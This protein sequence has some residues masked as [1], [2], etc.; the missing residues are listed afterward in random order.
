MSEEIRQI[1]GF[2][3][4]QALA[5]LGQLDSAFAKF[6][7]TVNQSAA[8]FNSFNQGAGKTVSAL[9]QMRSQADS[10]AAALG[11]LSATKA[12]SITAPT[13]STQGGQAAAASINSL[14][15]QTSAHAATAAGAF[16][17]LGNQATNA[18]T[19]SSR[20]ASN[21][22]LSLETI[23]RVIG[24]QVIVRA[25]NSIRSAVEDSFQGFIDFNRALAEIQTIS[26]DSLEQLGSEVR[27]LSDDFNTPILDV[28]KAK[29]EI[30]SN[31]FETTAESSQVLVAALKLSKVGLSDVGQAADLISTTLNS[32]N[33]SAG[34]AETISAK[35]FK[36]IELGR[37]KAS[38]LAS[39]FG[40]VAPV[41]AEI[42]ATEDEMLAAFSSITIGG[43]NASEAATQIRASLSALLKPS[44]DAEEALRKLGFETGE[45]LIQARGYRGALEALIGTTDGSTTSIAK[46][47]PNIRALNAVLRE[48]G[49]GAD[50]FDEHLRK[51]EQTSR[52]VLNKKFEVRISSDAE[53][54]ATDFQKLSNFFR[55]DLGAELVGATSKFLKFTG[56]AD[57]AINA[58]GKFAPAVGFTT[59]AL[60][61]YATTMGVAN[62]INTTFTSSANGANIAVQGLRGSLLGLSLGLG[63][64]SLGEFIGAEI[65]DQIT[66][67]RRKLE[68]EA[69][70]LLDFQRGQLDAQANLDKLSADKKFK[71]L[72]QQ[73][74]SARKAYFEETDAATDANKELLE[75]DRATLD[76]I[77]ESRERFAN[78]LRRATQQANSDIIDSRKRVADFEGR[79]SDTKFNFRNNRFNE[80]TQSARE[81]SRALEL[82]KLA[83]EKLGS[84]NRPEDRD[85]A[86]AEFQRAEAFAQQA[87]SSAATSRNVSA[88]VSAER[89]LEEVI[90]RRIESEKQ[91][92]QTR[93]EAAKKLADATAKEEARVTKLKS[94]AKDI[95]ADLNLFDKK[96]NLLPKEKID[97]NLKDAKQKLGQLKDT[98]FG[99][100]AKFELGDLFSIDQ[101]EQRVSQS[102]TNLEIKGLFASVETL[103]GVRD[104]IQGA[105]DDTD[106]V[107]SIAIDPSKLKGLTR[108]EQIDE[109]SNQLTAEQDA[110]NANR[111]ANVERVAAENEISK[112]I[113][114]STDSLK[115][116][117]GVLESI[118]TG[119]QHRFSTVSNKSIDETTAKLADIRLQMNRAIRNPNVTA[120]E[121]NSF[122]DQ[123][124]KL[125]AIAPRSLNLDLGRAAG[126]LSNLIQVFERRQQLIRLESQS[127]QGAL[128]T[129]LDMLDASSRRA[130]IERTSAATVSS[131]YGSTVEAS[132]QILRNMKATAV[133]A[134]ETSKQLSP[135]GVSP[136][137]LG[138]LMH[139]VSYL[140]AGGLAKGT[141][142]QLALLSQGEVVTNARS[143][144]RFRPQ[145][146]QI[147]AGVEPSVQR[148]S[149]DTTINVGDININESSQPRMTGT[150]VVDAIRRVQRHGT[151]RSIR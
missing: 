103:T 117:K 65:T 4:S 114:L 135:A 110:L 91:Y 147:A 128:Q 5:V 34:E 89:V 119:V 111:T 22:A 98:A 81:G 129:Q 44:K 18:L 73:V 56:G 3:A 97:A 1:F 50:I 55:V 107:I 145:L 83:A 115:E 31:G 80:L 139:P 20:S 24:T 124:T 95:L 54:V 149:G 133:A 146:Q 46:L 42:G 39:A 109:V 59:A 122:T 126:E 74:A 32:Y 82:A 16:N 37:V 101:L 137:A 88:Q 138:G 123:L 14:L 90:K 94:L 66:S 15:G 96:G 134:A 116:Q 40:R 118:A 64:K 23:T 136:K 48:S 132:A 105:L 33:K 29:Y 6:S 127:N 10:A 43:V 63:A 104:Q 26:P 19:R 92:Q 72:S 151:G 8:S 77:I 9:H 85:A 141:D 70:Q 2:D 120:E 87:I 17:N 143:A 144:Q 130:L 121:I 69:N 36:T 30:L 21:F 38:D 106:F 150:A 49:T 71:F 93:E 67:R 99:P 52:E 60:A 79:L 142:N 112:L 125:Q 51:I 113:A 86:N 45:Q 102:V 68:D 58:M 41:A 78:D 35:L 57:T 25:L 47:F 84:A 148:I 108:K 76:K 27:R 53:R 131:A 11:R 62:A 100:G 28:A 140:A 61:G 7:Q 12:P 13:I 75:N